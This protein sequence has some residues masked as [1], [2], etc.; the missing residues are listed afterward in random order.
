MSSIKNILLIIIFFHLFVCRFN[1]NRTVTILYVQVLMQKTFLPFILIKFGEF[2]A[3]M[4]MY[5]CFHRY[6]L[7]CYMY[8]A[9]MEALNIPYTL[10]MFISSPKEGMIKGLWKNHNNEPQVDIATNIETIISTVKF[11]WFLLQF[12]KKVWDDEKWWG[13]SKVWYQ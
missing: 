3:L 2:A 1:K 12:Y 6:Y 4:S 10:E 8:L 9:Q 7:K 13:N 5:W 11:C